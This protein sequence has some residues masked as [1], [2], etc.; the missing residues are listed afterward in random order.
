[1]FFSKK[2]SILCFL[3]SP[4]SSVIV[5]IV[6]QFLHF[7]LRCK[8]LKR[9]LSR[10]SYVLVVPPKPRPRFVSTIRRPVEPLV[11]SPEHIE[12]A[13]VGGVCVVDDAVGECER[14]HARRLAGVGGYV[15]AGHGRHIAYPGSVV[16]ARSNPVLT[17]PS[18]MSWRACCSCSR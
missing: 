6:P 18:R 13:R 9:P 11:H 15:G 14:A 2:V 16:E 8:K 1:M 5:F 4:F 17:A 10:I 3:S 12:A 7:T